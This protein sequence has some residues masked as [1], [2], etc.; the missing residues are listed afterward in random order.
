LGLRASL[1][2]RES[3]VE[4]EPQVSTVLTV[5]RDHKD[6]KVLPA[7]LE[8]RARKDFLDNHL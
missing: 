4:M 2:L 3:R 8:R 7:R 6:L 1:V 5:H